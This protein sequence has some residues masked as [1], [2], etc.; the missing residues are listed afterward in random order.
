MLTI[1][2]YSHMKS[3]RDYQ[4]AK[5]KTA[6]EEDRAE[7]LARIE[8]YTKELYKIP[9]TPDDDKNIYFVRYADDFLIGVKGSKKDC[10]EIKQELHDFLKEELKLTLSAEKT[11]I[12]HSSNKALFLGYN[13][14]VRR[15]QNV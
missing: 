9:R 12:T 11:L 15:K 14:T 13:V 6:K 7:I 8:K 3:K 4:K 1:Q 10:E 2:E 5:L